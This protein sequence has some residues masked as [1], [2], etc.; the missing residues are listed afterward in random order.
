MGPY[1]VSKNIKPTEG[2]M[3]DFSG[4]EPYGGQTADTAPAVENRNSDTSPHSSE[5]VRKRRQ[6]QQG[7]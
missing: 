1:K 7:Q 6:E 2:L 4:I 5:T 3:V